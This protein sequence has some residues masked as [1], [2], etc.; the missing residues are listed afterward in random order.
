MEELLARLR[1]AL[2]RAVA[3]REDVAV[4]KVDGMEVD[5]IRR[6]VIVD[7]VEVHLT[8]T[9]YELLRVFATNPDRVLTQR[10]LLI[11][12]LGPEY[13]DAIDFRSEPGP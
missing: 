4:I 10:T 9:Q 2:R 1:A 8:P 6:R 3:Q 11:T 12:V 13:E 7:G 5:Q